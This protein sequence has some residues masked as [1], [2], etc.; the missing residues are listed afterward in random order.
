MVIFKNREK[1][2]TIPHTLVF[3]NVPYRGRHVLTGDRKGVDDTGIAG[4]EN[5]SK[6]REK[7]SA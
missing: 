1:K 5:G 6:G 2:R 4:I 3:I 7:E